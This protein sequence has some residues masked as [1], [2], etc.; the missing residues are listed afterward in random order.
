M[1][2]IV[3]LG[4]ANMDLVVRQPRLARPGETL[5]GTSFATGPGGKGLN[6]AIAAARAAGSADT[7]AFLGC[8]GDDAFGHRLVEALRAAG[9][10]ADG[11]RTVTAPAAA[12]STGVAAISVT[13]DGE[14]AI[15]VVPGAN[16]DDALTDA[17]RRA[18]AGAAFLLVQ[19]ERP[20]TLVRAALELAR[21]AGVRTVLTPAPAVPAA[22]EL[23]PLAD[24]VIPND[25][26]AAVLLRALDPKGAAGDGPEAAARA[27][28]ARAAGGDGSGIAVVT[29]GAAGAIVA[30][31]GTLLAP[32]A[33]RAVH[34]VDTTGAGDTFAG[35]LVAWLAEGAEL[36]D[37]LAA[38]SAAASL[39]VTRPG[40]A[41]GMP[42]RDEIVAVLRG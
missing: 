4:S 33:A 10:D 6:Q 13:D 29:R 15:V 23:V 39:A 11:I 8:V 12:G 35:V 17:D 27:L 34:A 3:V 2:R 1:S 40:A 14:N 38:A 37:A 9:V 20:L 18:I 21:T 30:R 5:A 26:E 36:A 16:A 28:S 32:V 22:A 24:V 42:T 7:V 41:A 31:G 19:L 25:G